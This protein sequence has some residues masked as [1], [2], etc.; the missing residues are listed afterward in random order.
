MRIAMVSEHADP[1]ASPGGE[2]AGG[3]NVH[4]AALARALGTRDH[5]V[6]VYTRLDSPDAERVAH[7]APGVEVH[8]LPAGPAAPLPKDELLPHMAEFGDALGREW[9]R[10]PPHLVHAHFWMSGLASLQGRAGLRIPVAQTFHALGSVKARHQGARDTSPPG[11]IEAERRIGLACEQVIATCQDEVRELAQL[12]I[13]AEKVSVVPCGVDTA[14]FR[15]F[16]AVAPRNSRARLLT[17]GRLVQRKGIDTVIDALP[18]LPGAELVVA[19]GPERDRL[20]GDPEYRRLRDIARERGV[21]DRV[22]FTGAV[23]RMQV[24]ALIRSADVVVCTPWYEPFGIT[25]LEAMACGVPVVASTVG[26][27][28]DSVVHGT[29]GLLIPPRDPAAL[30][31]AAGTLL[32]DLEM[33]IAFG[34]AGTRR[35]RRWYS[36][37]RV[38]AQTESVYLRLG[39]G[40][41]PGRDTGPGQSVAVGSP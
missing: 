30:A 16:G 14:A 18:R 21:S 34:E 10:Q 39:A 36:W 5:A 37:P 22:I 20:A 27:L 31:A 32:T 40:V 6:V 38:A 23:P 33:R 3:Q 26:G 28:T 19:G 13:P 2:D 7:L 1:T 9:A 8:R 17:L 11:R 24:P 25:P 4:V 12:G 35:A 15:P 41:P 29:T